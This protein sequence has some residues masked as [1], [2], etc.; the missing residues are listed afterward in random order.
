MSR[1][2]CLDVEAVAGH[3]SVKTSRRVPE[4]AG[5]YQPVSGPVDQQICL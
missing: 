1:S 2:G 4:F 5:W 3:S